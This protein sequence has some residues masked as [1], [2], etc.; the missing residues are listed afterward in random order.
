MALYTTAGLLAF[1]TQQAR[2]PTTDN[3]MTSAQWYI[4]LSRAQREWMNIIGTICPEPNLSSPTQLASAD[5]N[6]SYT[7][8]VDSDGLPI[9]PIGHVELYDGP[10]GILLRPGTFD[11]T[12]CDYVPQGATIRF[13]GNVSRTFNNGLYA[14]FV[15]AQPPDIGASQEPTLAPVNARPLIGYRALVLYAQEAGGRDPSQWEQMEQQAW[16]GRPQMGDFGILG[17]LKSQFRDI[18]MQAISAPSNAW[19]RV[20]GWGVTG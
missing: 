17:M 6:V 8:G 5:G 16:Y 15:N 10:R 14:R 2:R 20:R 19:W 13:P 4:Y 1:V 18:G 11:D 7:F 3:E 12:G 9:T